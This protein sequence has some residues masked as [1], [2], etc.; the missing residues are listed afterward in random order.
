[1]QNRVPG[2]GPMP[3]VSMAKTYPRL[4]TLAGL[5]YVGIVRTPARLWP[6]LQKNPGLRGETRVLLTAEWR[7]V[8]GL[9]GATRL[10]SIPEAG[11]PFPSGLNY[12]LQA[13]ERLVLTSPV[14]GGRRGAPLMGSRLPSQSVALGSPGTSEEYLGVSA[15]RVLQS[16]VQLVKRELRPSRP[17]QGCHVE[18]ERRV[19]HGR[20]FPEIGPLVISKEASDGYPCDCLRALSC[21][22]RFSSVLAMTK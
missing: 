20:F 5:F 13:S 8:G 17:D 3:T 15:V 18:P 10:K 2:L 22:T 12:F 7:G 16:A 9:G 6:W 21:L 4:A 19:A 14:S 1:V 11:R